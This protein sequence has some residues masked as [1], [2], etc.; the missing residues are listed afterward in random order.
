MA[1]QFDKDFI[2]E[3]TKC[4]FH[5][6]EKRKK[7]WYVQLDLYKKIRSV[8]EKYN[9][10]LI[11]IGGT[12]LGAVRHGGYIPWDDDLDVALT[13]D[14]F[15]KLVKVARKEFREPYFFQYALS[16]KL[17]FCPWARLRRTD[18]TGIVR[19]QCN[20]VYNNGIFVDIFIFDKIPDDKVKLKK[21]TRRVAFYQHLLR[22][23]F[24]YNSTN[25]KYAFIKK[26]L[27]PLTKYFISYD[28]LYQ[29]YVKVCSKYNESDSKMYADLCA[30]SLLGKTDLSEDDFL[31]SIEVPFENTVVRI[32]K[33]YDARL[34][35]QYGN[36]MAFPPVK[37]RGLWHENV[38]IFDPDIPFL[39]YYK[40][41]RGVFIDAVKEY[42]F[43]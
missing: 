42:G 35:S 21:L 36:Y 40:N 9:L 5:I 3:E 41:H 8:C 25:K 33:N 1:V 37:D 34:T 15:E 22:N 11:V 29:K 26:I 30:L 32:P 2:K 7:I 28:S 31:E 39:E 6:E 14:D 4:G 19:T 16:D 12:A 27:F 13:R 17:I 23:Y 18:T 24:H 20:H 43:N 38:I 10:N